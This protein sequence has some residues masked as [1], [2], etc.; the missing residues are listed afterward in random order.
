MNDLFSPS[1]TNPYPTKILHI[2]A[3]HICNFNKMST[4]KKLFPYSLL[5]NEQSHL[6]AQI[7]VTTLRVK[8]FFVFC[9]AD[10]KE[11]MLAHWFNSV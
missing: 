11:D 10:E 3:I 7:L 8:N 5:N 1:P 6:I 4:P 2:Q 9:Q